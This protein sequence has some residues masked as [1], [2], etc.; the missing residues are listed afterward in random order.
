[1]LLGVVPDEVVA[2]RVMIRGIDHDALVKDNGFFYELSD[3]VETCQPLDSVTISY[4]DGSSDTIPDKM[5]GWAWTRPDDAS[6]P[7]PGE[8]PPRC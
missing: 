5:I 6:P 4:P 1:M 2:A 8:E 7:P 3:T